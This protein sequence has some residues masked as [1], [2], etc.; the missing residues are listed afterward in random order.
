MPKYLYHYTEAARVGSIFANGL[1][2]SIP[3]PANPNNAAFG[4]GQYFTDLTPD[5]ADTGSMQQVARA[6]FNYQL[7][8]GGGRRGDIVA[9]RINVSGLPIVWKHELW[10]RT[11][12]D[13]SIFVNPTRNTLSLVGRAGP[14]SVTFIDFK[15]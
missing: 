7:Y 13:R 12:G 5:E 2:A 6:L 1:N 8:W 4:P 14:G 3:D 10:S 11:F 9:I 15:Y